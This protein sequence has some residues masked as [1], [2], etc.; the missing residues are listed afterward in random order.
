VELAFPDRYLRGPD[1]NLILV[2]DRWVNLARQSTDD[3][4][5]GVNVWIPLGESPALS[6]PNRVEFSLFDTLFL[7]D[8]T[9]IRSGVPPLDLLNGAPSGVSGGQPR[10][11]I[12]FHALVHKNGIGVL[13]AAAWRSSTVVGSGAAASPDPITFSALGTADLRVFAD[14]GRMPLTKN[15][16]WAN[17][18]RMSLSLTNIADTRQ[19][20]RDASGATPTAFL[21]G[22]LD[23]PGRVIAITARKLF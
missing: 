17:G 1:G 15:H 7:H 6:W 21:P 22:Y 9:V 16:A 2:D 13:L 4:K 5:W 12:E 19:R 14:F 18:T 10:H 20:V 8:V 11:T 23:P 3:L